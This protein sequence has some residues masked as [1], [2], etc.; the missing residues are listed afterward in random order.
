MSGLLNF[1][2]VSRGRVEDPSYIHI[3]S[4]VKKYS[5]QIRFRIEEMNRF[6]PR[7][8]LLYKLI[9][10]MHLQPWQNDE[11]LIYTVRDKMSSLA[12]SFRLTYHNN[13]GQLH[14]GAIIPGTREAII[15]TAKDEGPVLNILYHNHSNLNWEIGNPNFKDGLAFI[16]INLVALAKAYY[17]W[18]SLS[19]FNP[20]TDNL[21]Q[22]IYKKIWYPLLP[23]YMDIAMY[24]RHIYHGEGMVL[25]PDPPVREYR[26]PMIEDRIQRHV[27]NMFRINGTRRLNVAG[28]L[29]QIPLFTKD[30][31]LE[32]V[33]KYPGFYTNQSRWIYTLAKL[34][35]IYNAL[36]Y[37][38]STGK[39][40]INRR[41]IGNLNRFVKTFR[42]AK[43]IERLPQADRGVLLQ[44]VDSL[45]KSLSR[46]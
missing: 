9:R 25:P 42:M 30:T 38:A 10:A 33:P 4:V 15:L 37:T 41:W 18:K 35:Y 5:T 23:Q 39:Q 2:T 21:Y 27:E 36:D 32:L 8:H 13:Y 16:E 45:D 26:I 28:F 3:K 6:V 20:D 44:L 40:S 46:Y 22:H 31:A 24:N 14:D 1:D 11:T 29:E 12:T 17:Q 7:D 43:T 34:P 19:E